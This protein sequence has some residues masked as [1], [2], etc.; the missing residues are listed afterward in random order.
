MGNMSKELDI[1]GLDKWNFNF[2]NIEAI[3]SIVRTNMNN[4]IFPNTN[5]YYQ[6]LDNEHC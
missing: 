5:L 3:N 1:Y 4:N 6:F 2:S